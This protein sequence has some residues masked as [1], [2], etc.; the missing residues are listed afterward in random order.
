LII[1]GAVVAVGMATTAPIFAQQGS[2][3]VVLTLD[4]QGAPKLDDL[5]NPVPG[6]GALQNPCTGEAVNVLGT[7]TITSFQKLGN[8]GTITTSVTEVSKG[9]GTGTVTGTIYP[10]SESQNFNIKT[11]AAT[12]QTESDFTDKIAMKGPQKIDNWV[13]RAHFRIT[14]NNNGVVTSQ[15]DNVT[16]DQCKG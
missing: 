8:N 11:D 7:I 5:G 12:F 1:A 4:R 13:F 14:I 15:F 6:T 9:T 2:T 16:V 10:F 3:T